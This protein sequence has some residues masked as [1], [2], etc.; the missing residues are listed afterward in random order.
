[1]L[2]AFFVAVGQGISL[3]S[4]ERERQAKMKSNFACLAITL[5]VAAVS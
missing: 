3:L 5:G 2:A 4:T 1:M